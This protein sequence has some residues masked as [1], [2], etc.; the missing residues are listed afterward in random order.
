MLNCGWS[1]TRENYSITLYI[2]AFS[3]DET[4][5]RMMRLDMRH[6]VGQGLMLNCGRSS[7]RESYSITCYVL[8][9]SL[10]ETFK[11]MIGFDIRLAVGQG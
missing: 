9:F 11:T 8:A 7:T 3:L 5:E 6:A 2:G 1:S 4:F 10:D